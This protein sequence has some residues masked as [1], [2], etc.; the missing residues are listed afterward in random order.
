[1]RLP[2]TLSLSTRAMCQGAVERLLGGLQVVGAGQSLI[3]VASFNATLVGD[4][5]H[6]PF[7]R[8]PLV[9]KYPLHRGLKGPELQTGPSH[10]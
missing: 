9:F 7:S 3:A 5:L 8:S 4:H 10:T 6:R 1:M 2:I